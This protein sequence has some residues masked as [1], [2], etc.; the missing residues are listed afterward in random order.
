MLDMSKKEIYPAINSYISK[1]LKVVELKKANGISSVTDIELIKKLNALNETIYNETNKLSL[2]VDK[3]SEITE[4]YKKAS[5]IIKDEV[6]PCME[7]LRSAADEA[8]T[9]TDEKYWPYPSYAKL[10]FSVK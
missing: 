10:L 5:L 7:T 3:V 1:L 2:L 6:L 4:D 9:L 8:E